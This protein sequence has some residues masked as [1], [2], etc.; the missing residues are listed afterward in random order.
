MEYFPVIR[1]VS[2]F[3]RNAI[4]SINFSKA[5]L[6]LTCMETI[7]TFLVFGFFIG[8]LFIFSETFLETKLYICVSRHDT[9]ADLEYNK[10]KCK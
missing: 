5:M 10:G 6:T 1:Y 3:I 4:V 2:F 8:M 9:C 7:L